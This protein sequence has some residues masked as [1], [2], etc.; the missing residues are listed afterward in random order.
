MASVSM[1]AAAANPDKSRSGLV[2]ELDAAVGGSINGS[3]WSATVGNN[4]VLNNS[5]VY[6]SYNEGTLEIV[7]SSL[8]SA[9]V[10]NF[11]SA[12]TVLTAEAWIY[13]KAFPSAS[14]IAT[15]ITESYTGANDI[16][17]FLGFLTP[18]SSLIEG[19][20]FKSGSF[21][22]AGTFVANLNTWY[23]FALTIDGTNIKLYVNGVLNHSVAQ[24][25]AVPGGGVEPLL[26][27]R[28]WDTAGDSGN[29]LSALIPLIRVY[30]RALSA[31][32]VLSNYSSTKQRYTTSLSDYRRVY[33]DDPTSF[34]YLPMPNGESTLLAYMQSF[35]VA[36][37]TQ[38]TGSSQ[39]LDSFSGNLFFTQ[40][41]RVGN[42]YFSTHGRVR[43]IESDGQ[44]PADGAD[45]IVFN[46]GNTA[47]TNADY[48]NAT[49]VAR[50]QFFGGEAV[51]SG[52]V[53]NSAVSTGEIWGYNNKF[54][55]LLLYRLP[56]GVANSSYS[57]QTGY[58]FSTGTT[59]MSGNG[60]RDEYNTT[61]ITH[62][63]FTVK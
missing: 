56:L 19:G 17:F 52:G 61:S 8:Q 29:Y 7:K 22:K 36:A 53:G 49:T 42:A 35:G 9:N 27:G 44:D 12:L 24:S 32:E 63:G 11:G 59:V 6:R 40:Q 48:D 45:W 62:L 5:P 28:K 25:G 39:W 34:A 43:I 16:N 20:F 2:L 18:G 54:G 58:Y 1:V 50:E 37:S 21:Y 51:F 60:K 57:H 33:A 31:V 23:H 41:P 10:V 55:W 3:T 30:N 26:I 38:A 14:A 13:V 4:A 15:I 46:F 47:I